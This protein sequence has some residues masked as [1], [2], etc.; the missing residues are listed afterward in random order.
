MKTCPFCAEQIQDAAIVCK[1]CGRELKGEEESVPTTSHPAATPTEIPSSTSSQS[2]PRPRA[3]GLAS[4]KKRFIGLGLVTV[5]LIVGYSAADSEGPGV[6]MLVTIP[7]V[8]V[9]LTGPWFLRGLVAVFSAALLFSP[10]LPDS[11]PGGTSV[12]QESPDPTAPILT[13]SARQTAIGAISQYPEILDVGLSQDGEVLSL[14]LVVNGS[15]SESRARELGD[16]FVRLVKTFS[17]D[18][19]PGIEIGLGSFDYLV[20]VYTPTETEI[21]LGAK[22]RNATRITW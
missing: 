2:V 18:S 12:A 14:V 16:N 19:S 8:V 4:G 11:E 1:H 9:L 22:S 13:A 3:L 17:S 20:G 7:G 15:I 10:L 6:G 5:G 21:A